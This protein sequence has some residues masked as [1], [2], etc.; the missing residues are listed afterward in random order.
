MQRRFSPT[1]HLRRSDGLDLVEAGGGGHEWIV[2]RELCAY[3]VVD[4][5]AV[6]AGKRRDFAATAVRRW[7]PFADPQSHVEW[8]GDRAMVW[9]WSRARVLGD[10]EAAPVQAQPRRL[11]PE[12]LFRG[13]PHASGEE[14]VAMDHGVEGR[15]WRGNVLAASAWWAAPPSLPEWNAFLR[16]A[17]MPIMAE[18]PVATATTLATAPWS[19]RRPR[20]LGE[21]AAH[22]R[23]L[24]V[25]A[26]AGI[27][28]AVLAAP[29]VAAV[30]LAVSIGQVEAEIA[31]QDEGLQRI[32]AAREQAGRD[33]DAIRE[34]L[35]LRP[36]ASQVELVAEV[37]ALLPATGEWQLREWRMADPR[38]LEIVL[39]MPEADPAALVQAWE[40]SPRFSAVSVDLLDAPGEIGIRAG[41]EPLPVAPALVG[42]AQ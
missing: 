27:T 10:A 6:P 28:V 41:I 35:A 40:A 18:V 7:S 22:Y 36:P 14:L 4:A 11:F 31:D 33:A 24:L 15:V 3:T 21:M 38:T 16:G 23:S 2:A 25:A 39:R 13:M 34:L 26:A 5:S 1:R 12:S 37:A 42:A 17:G 29:L 9:A 8:V 32:L 20:D 19:A 30:A